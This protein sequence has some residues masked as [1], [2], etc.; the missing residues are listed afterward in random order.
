MKFV[1]ILTSDSRPEHFGIGSALECSCKG[2]LKYVRLDPL[3]LDLRLMKAILKEKK[4]LLYRISPGYVSRLLELKLF[5]GNAVAFYNDIFGQFIGGNIKDAHYSIFEKN[6]VTIPN[7]IYTPT[8]NK[9]L[10]RQ[11]SK[12]LGGF[13]I[14]VKITDSAHGEGVKKVDSLISLQ[15]ISRNLMKKKVN[16]ILQEF[17]MEGNEHARCIV[18]GNKVIDSVQY[19]AKKGSYISN[20]GDS[21]NVEEKKFSKEVEELAIKATHALGLE[22]GGVDIVVSKRKNYVLEVNFPCNFMRCQDLTGKNISG[23]VVDYLLKKSRAN[24]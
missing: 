17:I 12:E 5:S 22:F 8:N 11:F 6:N 24:I 4:I 10:L 18:L 15:K 23:L 14:I 7:T 16:F 1:S 9:D 19:K 20:A 3:N 21:P 13:P 2:K